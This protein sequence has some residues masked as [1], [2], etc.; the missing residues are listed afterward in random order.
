VFEIGAG[1]ARRVRRRHW[2]DPEDAEA[3]EAWLAAVLSKADLIE[4]WLKARARRGR[5]PAA[6][7]SDAVPGFKIVQGRQGNRA[8]SNASEAEAY[9]KAMRLKVEE[10]Y[11]LKLISPTSAEKLAKAKTI[12]PRQW[13][14]LAGARSPAAD[15]KPHVAPVTD[16][17]PALAI[18]PV[19][20][21]FFI[22]G[23]FA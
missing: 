10:M 5:A 19:A 11:D 23:E 6:R 17:R 13:K 4:D 18:T 22:E 8:W 14:T 16:P 9:L 20:D 12:G 7:R 2:R 1:V 3:S 15:G 21:E